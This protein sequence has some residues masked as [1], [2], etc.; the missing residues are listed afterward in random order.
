MEKGSR[1]GKKSKV[2]KKELKVLKVISDKEVVYRQ[3]DMNMDKET[4]D[5]LIAYGRAHMPLKEVN[6]MYL[7]WAFEFALK[8]GIEQSKS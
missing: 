6:Q 8:E 5:T 1:K 2:E 7:N 3:I 4:Q